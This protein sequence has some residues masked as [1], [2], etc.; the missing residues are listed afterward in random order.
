VRFTYSL[1]VTLMFTCWYALPPQVSDVLRSLPGAP[2]M[3]TRVLEGLFKLGEQRASAQRA[4]AAAA[5]GEYRPRGWW[6]L[7]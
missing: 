4:V 2:D 5:V 7:S 6:V 3:A 1:L